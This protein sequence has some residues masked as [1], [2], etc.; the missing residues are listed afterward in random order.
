[1]ETES[2]GWQTVTLTQEQKFKFRLRLEQEQAQQQKVPQQ[3]GGYELPASVQKAAQVLTTPI[4]GIRALGVGTQ[5]AM[6]GVNPLPFLIPGA[7]GFMNSTNALINNMPNALERASA[8]TQP[9]YK[10]IPGEK[11]GSFLGETAGTAGLTAP[12]AAGSGLTTLA[13]AG[14]GALNAGGLNAI[15]DASEEGR[16]NPVKTAVN[17]TMGGLIPIAVSPEVKSFS[18]KVAGALGKIQSGVPSKVGERLFNDPGAF[19]APSEKAAAQKLVAFREGAGL[20]KVPETI[21]EIVSPEAGEARKY[22]SKIAEQYQLSK[23][24]RAEPVTGSQLLKA[25]Q[26]LDDIIEVTPVKQVQARAKL[27][28]LKNKITEVLEKAAPGDKGAALEYSRSALASK[29]RKLLPVTAQGDISLSRTLGLPAVQDSLPG[30]L[31]AMA[32]GALQSPALG[33]LAISSAGGLQKAASTVA[34]N[35]I[36]RQ[37]IQSVIQQVGRALSEPKIKEYLKKAKNN[38][39]KARSLAIK[40][41]YDPSLPLTND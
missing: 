14:I 28:E 23:L 33:G 34:N 12:L 20:K 25:K 37:A 31:G 15:Q 38:K 41:G 11:I 29:F 30:A 4:R 2:I 39:D 27:F 35:P 32:A 8:A 24:G 9:G 17:A 1:M 18:G 19:L 5:R 7:P 3:S 36:A 21:K 22:V 40:D 16:F 6:E 10:A 26:S 13:K